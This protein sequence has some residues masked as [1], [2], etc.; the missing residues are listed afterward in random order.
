MADEFI[1]QTQAWNAGLKRKR[2]TNEERNEAHILN[3]SSL[4]QFHYSTSLVFF[5]V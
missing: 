5:Q 3:V 4:G 2:G 1:L